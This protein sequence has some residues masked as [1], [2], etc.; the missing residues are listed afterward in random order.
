MTIID[1]TE[2][3]DEESAFIEAT[4]AME[5][6]VFPQGSVVYIAIQDDDLTFI[7]DTPAVDGENITLVF[8]ADHPVLSATCEIVGGQA[9]SQI[10]CEFTCIKSMVA[11]KLISKRRGQLLVNNTQN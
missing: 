4:V 3:E 9:T 2:L 11:I 10:N 7:D 1:D 6:G 8:N 5:D